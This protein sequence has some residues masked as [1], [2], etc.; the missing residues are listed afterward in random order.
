MANPFPRT[1]RSLRGERDVI[2]SL[3]LA[4]C[5]LALGVWSAWFLGARLPVFIASDT[6]RLEAGRAAVPIA[7]QVGGRLR[8][9]AVTVGQRVAAGDL[10]A[11]LDTEVV[12]RRLDE[13]RARLAALVH[14]LDEMRAQKESK[15]QGVAAARSGLDLAR[16]EAAEKSRGAAAAAALAAEELRRKESLHRQGVL[17]DAE[18]STARTAAEQRRAEADGLAISKDL[19]IEERRRDAADR[20]ANLQETEGTLAAIEGD[21]RAQDAVVRRL[22]A[23]SRQRSVRAPVAG[24]IGELARLESGAVV[25]PGERLGMLVP[26]AGLHVL[27][28]F[29]PAAALGRLR[30]GQTAEIRL[31]AFPWAEFGGVPV[32]VER[33]ASELRQGRVW[34]ELALVGQPSGRIPLQHGLAGSVLVETERLSPAGL[35]L[36]GL[37][38]SLA[39]PAATGARRP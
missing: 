23:E 37:G 17:S 6:A 27:A 13:E 26:D 7:P 31:D 19:L 25:Q 1:T 21:L 8:R 20:A 35:L 2:Q 10:L 14:R 38:K 5:V 33:V 11:E 22:E 3:F 30:P 24:R 15:I 28:G 4:A 32:R 16:R 9:I 36:R 18:L 39:P 12:G 29:P 34:V